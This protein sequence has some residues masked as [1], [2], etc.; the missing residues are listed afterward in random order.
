[1]TIINGIEIDD[2][3]YIENDIHQAIKNNSPI[4]EKLNMV[5]CISNVCQYA[6]RYILAKEFIARIERDYKEEIDLYIVEL[7]Y[8][9]AGKSSQHFQVTEKGNRK[10]LQLTTD[11]PALWM[12]ENMLNLGTKL[13]PSGWKA[14]AFCDADIEFDNPHFALDTL[15]I[16]NGTR[17]I[18]QMFS[19]CRD[20]NLDLNPMS[21]FS[22]FGYQYTTGKKYSFGGGINYWHPGFNIAMT[23]EAYEQMNG[24]YEVSILGSGDHNLFLSLIQNGIKSVNEEV[25]EGYKKSII[26]FDLR[27]R[28][29]RLG[30]TPGVISHYFHGSKKNRQYSERWKI[31]VK[32]QYDPFIHTTTDDNGLLIPTDKCPSELLDDIQLY[33]ESRNEDEYY[34]EHLMRE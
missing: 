20:L 13:L 11:S 26:D 9:I 23:R 29:L 16:L 4:E 6:R 12:K 22:S 25:S 27:C 24:L 19:H 18:V 8:S 10:H 1:M 5:I 15:K 30:Y 33:F 7:V 28:G 3:E 32:H 31:L 2:I 17:D 14:V 21:I 34:L